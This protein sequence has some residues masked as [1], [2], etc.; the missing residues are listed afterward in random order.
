M[1][2]AGLPG[3]RCMRAVLRGANLERMQNRQFHI[4]ERLQCPLAGG[5]VV[6]VI[7]DQDELILK[8]RQD[9]ADAIELVCGSVRSIEHVDVEAPQAG[10]VDAAKVFF[11][12]GDVRR[13]S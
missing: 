10:E 1:P 4:V 2:V 7:D 5:R 13:V 11:N 12:K 6:P 9:Q 3:Q 8:S